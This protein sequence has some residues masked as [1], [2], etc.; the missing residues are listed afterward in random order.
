MSTCGVSVDSSTPIIDRNHL[1]LLV[2]SNFEESKELLDDLIALYE[3]ENLPHLQDLEEACKTGDTDAATRHTHFIAG[4]SGNMGLAR[5][6]TYCR[7]VESAI[8][9]NIEPPSLAHHQTIKELYSTSVESFKT[10]V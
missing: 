9:D 8:R 4:S 7:A 6:S 5:L 3:E 1:E 2:G 10:L